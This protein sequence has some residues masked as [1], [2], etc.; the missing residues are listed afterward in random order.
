MRLLGIAK[1][2]GNIIEARVHPTFIPLEHPLAAVRDSFNAIFVKGDAVGSL[3]LYGRGAGDLPTG[4]AI[5]SDIITACHRKN[6]H[7]YMDF[8]DNGGGSGDILF[9]DDWETGFF[10]RLTVKD[11]PGVLARIAG[12]FGRYQVSIASV[13]QKDY[14]KDTAPLIF[15]THMAKELSMQKAM[16]EIGLEE[17]VIKVENVIR[18]ER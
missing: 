15:V 17:D 16:K 4:S 10:V 3:M 2:R 5:I 7:K 1:D 11:K 6:R 14:G 9:N 18:V 13:I 8:S 12:I